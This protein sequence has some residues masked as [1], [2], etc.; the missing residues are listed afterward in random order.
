MKIEKKSSSATPHTSKNNNMTNPRKHNNLKENE[1]YF[2]YKDT[3][4]SHPAEANNNIYETIIDNRVNVSIETNH[5][6]KPSRGIAKET[7]A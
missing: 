7:F 5:Y 6:L 3:S 1:D 2:F 4:L